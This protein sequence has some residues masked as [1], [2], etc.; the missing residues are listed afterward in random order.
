MSTELPQASGPARPRY[1][2]TFPDKVRTW[3]SDP[4]VIVMREI[5]L[6]EEQQAAIAAGELG[7][8]FAIEATKHSIVSADGKSVTWEDGGKELFLEA[9]SPQVRELILKAYRRIHQ[10]QAE[11]EAD[12]FGGMTVVV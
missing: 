5:T 6:A 4:K 9:C 10:P 1:R 12:F 11:A 2:F 7:Y 3:T 8:K